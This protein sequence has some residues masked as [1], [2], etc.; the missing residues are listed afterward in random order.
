L[1]RKVSIHKPLLID[2]RTEMNMQNST[3]LILFVAGTLLILIGGGMIL[4]QVDYYSLAGIQI[5][6]NANLL[7]AISIPAG[8]LLAAGVNVI[9]CIFVRGLFLREPCWWR[10]CTC[11]TPSGAW[12]ACPSR[13]C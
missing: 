9:A 8:F 3:K 13:V 12:L 10:F 7:N 5:G 1:S 2:W 11:L 4:T 6:N